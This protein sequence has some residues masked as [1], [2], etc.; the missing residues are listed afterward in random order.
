MFKRLNAVTAFR[1]D[2][3]KLVEVIETTFGKENEKGKSTF[4]DST[5]GDLRDSYDVF[6]KAVNV[7]DISK[8]G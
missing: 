4:K 3:Y 8:E 5:L 7:L 1:S 2:H 6:C